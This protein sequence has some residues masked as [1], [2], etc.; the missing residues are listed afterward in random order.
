MDR[1]RTFKPLKKHKAGTT[2]H[3]LAQMTIKTLGSGNLLEAVILPRGEEKTEWLALNTVD[4]FNE[5]ALLYGVVADEAAAKHS[6]EGEGYP[7]SVEYR[8]LDAAHKRPIRCSAPDY[9][10]YVMTWVEGQLQNESIFPSRESDPFPEDFQKHVKQIFK[11]LFRVFAIIY[12][13]HLS[14]M[15]EL[16]ADKHLNTCFKHFVFFF[17]EFDLVDK[18][19]IAA[20]PE[21]TETFQKEYYSKKGMLPS[22][23]TCS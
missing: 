19:E 1:S 20:L 10:D 14:A 12:A 2:R 5:M 21:P 22:N 8:W 7:P 6:K 17:Q 16:E 3:R 11:R 13:H 9:V 23:A 15:K 18:K 4:F